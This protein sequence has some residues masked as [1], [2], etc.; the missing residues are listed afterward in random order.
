M[1]FL[2]PDLGSSPVLDNI[3][4][5]EYDTSLYVARSYC[6]I[7]VTCLNVF[8]P[9]ARSYLFDPKT[10]GTNRILCF[11][12]LLTGLLCLYLGS[13]VLL[14]VE[15]YF[16]YEIPDPRVAYAHVFCFLALT[17]QRYIFMAQGEE[18]KFWLSHI[19]SWFMLC[20]LE[21]YTAVHDLRRLSVSSTLVTAG[22]HICLALSKLCIYFTLLL[23]LRIYWSQITTTYPASPQLYSDS[24]VERGS[25]DEGDNNQ[26]A[27][28]SSQDGDIME[29]I[30]NAGGL[31]PWIKKFK[32]FWKLVWPVGQTR[33]QVR[34]IMTI[35]V[36]IV[37]RLIGF[38]TT[39]MFR[40]LCNDFQKGTSASTWF[41]FGILASLTFGEGIILPN[42]RSYL[43]FPVEGYR[44]RELRNATH[45]K[46]MSLGAS[47]HSS[48]SPTEVTGA[49]DLA[50]G[51][52]Q[53][54]DGV[55]FELSPN[56]LDLCLATF[57]LTN[58]GP[59]VALNVVCCIILSALIEQ[60]ELSLM[61]PARIRFTDTQIA[62]ETSRQDGLR[63][64]HT[65]ANFGRIAYEIKKATQAVT[66]W[67]QAKL[68]CDLFEL[69]MEG[70]KNLV[71]QTG[72][73][74]ALGLTFKEIEMG[75]RL[76]GDIT[77]LTTFYMQLIRSANFF[78]SFGTEQF[79]ALL[80]SNRLRKILELEPDAKDG[81]E[82][83]KI[84]NGRL[85]FK[86]VTFE[87]KN[88]GTRVL[89][90]LNLDIEGGRKVGIVGPNGMGK[91][92][93]FE[94]LMR[95][96][97]LLEGEGTITI[98]G[99]DINT[100]TERTLHANIGRMEQNP[101]FFNDTV[102]QNIT[103]AMPNA[104]TEELHRACRQAEIFD[105]IM[106]KEQKFDTPMGENGS[107][108]SGGERQRIGLARLFL[109]NPSIILID[110]GTSALDSFTDARIWCNLTTEFS[111]RT[112]IIIAHR[113]SNIRNADEIIA[114]GRNGQVIERGTHEKLLANDSYYAKAWRS[115]IAEQQPVY[116]A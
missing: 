26:R 84:T 9:L 94:L 36:V 95:Q 29:E 109:L 73:V 38:I 107:N 2:D 96:E 78:T 58:L 16:Q 20:T 21:A 54:F 86:N 87:Y 97:R 116:L 49:V 11:P 79:K 59:W 62:Q 13:V 91:S 115:H 7:L 57:G 42:I 98:D 31:W 18:E 43:W 25:T 82:E 41:W 92:T 71:L 89:T 24:D 75:Q 106:N 85:E 19:A 35:A 30:A 108:F 76:I 28:P 48:T 46:V 23:W 55:F 72:Y 67:T 112:I 102:G 44:T 10:V 90:N 70:Y 12:Y 88:T 50:T 81:V 37:D 27:S 45:T 66:A 65:I 93:L 39:Y 64:Y 1:L 3:W 34:F 15:Y 14:M 47:Y 53:L 68:D 105:V 22:L 52:G 56:T 74:V 110:E 99:Q 101:Y 114:L 51:V 8:L 61:I 77:A 83:L 100:V 5:A 6:A 4:P 113:L 80:D 103:Y 33:L 60:T 69:H 40:D 104:T 111:K 63:G 17:I 32:I